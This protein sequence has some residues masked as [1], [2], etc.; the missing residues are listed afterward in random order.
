ME[1]KPNPLD[2]QVGG[3]H[4]IERGIQPIEY[5]LSNNLNFPEGCVIKYVTRHRYKNGKQDLI[6]AIH[7][8]EFLINHEYPEA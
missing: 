5:I 2:R 8:L 6:K 4:Y 7:Y 3:G 1:Q